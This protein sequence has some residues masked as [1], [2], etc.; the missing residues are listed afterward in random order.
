VLASHV[1]H[2][3]SESLRGSRLYLTHDGE[4][5]SLEIVEERHP[6]LRAVAVAVDEVR[7][8]REGDAPPLELVVGGVDVRDRRYSTDSADGSGLS[9]RNKRVPPQSKKESLPNV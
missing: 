9:S 6:L 4:R 1:N 3:A 5:T 2:R 8:A 7:R